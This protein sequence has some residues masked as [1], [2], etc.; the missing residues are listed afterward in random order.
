MVFLGIALGLLPC[1]ARAERIRTLYTSDQV[2]QPVYLAMGRSTILRFDEKPKTAVIGNANYFSLEYINND[3]TIQP[4]GVVVTNLFVYTES[5]TYGL[6]LKVGG[7][8]GQYD[9]LVQVRF[10]PSYLSLPARALKRPVLVSEAALHS[11]FVMKGVLEFDVTKVIKSVAQGL[12]ILEIEISNLSK[13]SI[14]TGEIALSLTVGG[15][16]HPY[17][18][19]TIQ[20]DELPPGG[21]TDARLIARLADL[22]SGQLSVIYHDHAGVLVLPR[23]VLK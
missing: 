13:L 2:M 22:D 9:D 3:I 10:R 21:K 19:A 4:Q 6:I 15:K 17:Q 11:R 5:Q 12:V 18:K 16:D 1:T 7:Q 23:R 14:K 20:K 8:G